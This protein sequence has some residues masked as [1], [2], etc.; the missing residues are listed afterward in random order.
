MAAP[1]P[2]SLA[3]WRPDQGPAALA[4]ELLLL[5]IVAGL[6][7]MLA[8]RWVPPQ[9]LPWRPLELAHPVGLFTRVK[10]NRAEGTGCRAI[11][12]R[13]DVEFRDVAEQTSGD[14]CSKKD[15][16]RLVGGAVLRPAGPVMTCKSALALSI[17]ERQVVR[18]A[19]AEVLGARLA[20]ID[21]YGSYA[22][23][24]QYGA[25]HGRVSEHPRANAI[26]V[27]AFRLADGRRVSV[28]RDWPDA[29]P[30]AA[31]L[32]RVHEGACG[33]F[34]VTLSPEY[35]AAHADHLHLDMGRGPFCR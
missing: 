20:A 8:E 19:A 11:L 29:G 15:A 18:P 27:A 9:H 13:G 24:R 17:W 6:V 35:N 26:D 2:S 10:L 28:L 3:D 23:R 22:C 5:L 25:A 21:H 33:I 4:A 1:R 32:K 34:D 30:R 16:G 31:F 14:F 7:V 12:Q